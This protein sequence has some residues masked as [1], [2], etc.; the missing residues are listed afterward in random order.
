MLVGGVQR[1]GNSQQAANQT[2]V[3]WCSSP[4]GARDVE[5]TQRA[6]SSSEKKI[7]A[8]FCQTMQLTMYRVAFS[9]S[10]VC[11]VF[12]VLVRVLQRT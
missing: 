4:A 11:G 7:S 9:S 10:S 2:I 3:L 12:L 8:G 6:S 5:G 1:D